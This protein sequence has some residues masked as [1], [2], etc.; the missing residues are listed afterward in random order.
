MPADAELEG[1]KTVDDAGPGTG[2][3]L[4]D[5]R[6][7]LTPDGRR[8]LGMFA[9]EGL[10]LH[11]RALRGGARVVRAVAGRSLLGPTTER[12]RRLV[13]GLRSG[14][15]ELHAVDDDILAELTAGRGTGALVG[16]VAL[17][18]PAPLHELLARHPRPASVLVAVDV[19]DPGNV[20]AL[21]RTALASGAA[22]LVAVGLSD[23]FHPRAVRTSMGSVFKLPIH[24][25]ERIEDVLTA[26]EGA[27]VLKLG[28]VA[29]GGLAPFRAALHAPCAAV[30]IGSEPFGLRPE[31]VAR[32][33]RLVTVPMATGVD[34]FSVNAVAAVLLYELQR[35]AAAPGR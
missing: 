24:R 13:E 16:L 25:R 6:R 9:I 27:G 11:E 34:S 15:C 8:A 17:P 14:G 2:G 28:A 23:P 5:I 19:A 32:M 22:A 31:T 35:Q 12:V 4:E 26:L 18:Q 3:V 33:D 1:R 21:S 29:K 10:R 7:A 20:G 30:F